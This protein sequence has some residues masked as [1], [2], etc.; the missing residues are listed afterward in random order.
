MF[1]TIQNKTEFCHK[2]KK[3]AD[4]VAILASTEV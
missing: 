1:Y 4:K 2:K 3:K